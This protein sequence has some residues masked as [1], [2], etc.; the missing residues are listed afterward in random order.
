MIFKEPEDI[1]TLLEKYSTTC[2][3]MDDKR[4]YW[5]RVMVLNGTINHISVISWLSVLLVLKSVADY[6][7]LFTW[8]DGIVPILYLNDGSDYRL[9]PVELILCMLQ[10]M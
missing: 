4:W 10:I 6:R 9:S 2:V 8:Y 1:N 5:V 3:Q 7:F